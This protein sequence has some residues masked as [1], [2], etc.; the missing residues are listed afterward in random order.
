M[1]RHCERAARC[2]SRR[3]TATS[4]SATTIPSPSATAVA[5]VLTF[6]IQVIET[7]LVGRDDCK[8]TKNDADRDTM[9]CTNA[10]A[11]TSD[12]RDWPRTTCHQDVK[13]RPDQNDTSLVVRGTHAH[14]DR[15]WERRCSNRKDV[16]D[17]SACENSPASEWIFPLEEIQHSTSE[18]RRT[19]SAATCTRRCW[20]RPG[21][22]RRSK[23]FSERA[24]G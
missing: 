23:R 8:A 5:T 16:S 20:K 24:L 17:D 15:G 6:R 12:S 14:D 1:V 7:N 18:W 21:F 13:G 22:R 4:D 10:V 2:G 3:A 11:D 9:R 19:T